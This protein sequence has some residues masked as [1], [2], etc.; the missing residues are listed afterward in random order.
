MSEII[1]NEELKNNKYFSK[2]IK[3]NL[4]LES[5]PVAIK[6]ILHEENV[7]EDIEKID[8]KLRHCGMV[9]KASQGSKFYSTLKEQDCVKGSATIGLQEFPEKIAT[10]EFD[11]EAGHF[12][13]IASAKR[14]FDRVPK[15]DTNSYGIIYSPLEKADFD[16]DII[17]IIANP[18]QAMIL[19]QAINYTLGGRIEADF[20]GF[21][22]VCADALAGPYIN[23]RPNISVACTG[24]RKFGKIQDNE[25]V[26]GLNGEN[27][28]CTVNALNNVPY[29]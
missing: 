21:Q 26:V 6:F 22:A 12:K 4:T 9:Q 28:G 29:N 3:K 19:A 10:G 8:E 15:M 16:P 18:K 20:A 27:I 13:S 24:S 2:E 7:P 1:E 23:K 14:T 25:L 5:S 11:Y 17:I